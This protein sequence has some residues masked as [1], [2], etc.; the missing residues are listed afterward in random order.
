MY[1][2]RFDLSE[3]EDQPPY[4]DTQGEMEGWTEFGA[5]G[6]GG[7]DWWINLY[8]TVKLVGYRRSAHG[9]YQMDISLGI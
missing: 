9:K 3:N 4:R 7:L 2:S 5:E 8:A 6:P 1:Y